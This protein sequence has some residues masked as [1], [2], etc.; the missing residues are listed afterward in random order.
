VGH[1]GSLNATPKTSLWGAFNKTGPAGKAGRLQTVMSTATGYF[2]GKGGA[3]TEVPR[4]PLVKELISKSKYHATNA[5]RKKGIMAVE[6]DV[7]I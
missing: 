4:K 6:V 2:G 7:P 5:P 1:H 3:E